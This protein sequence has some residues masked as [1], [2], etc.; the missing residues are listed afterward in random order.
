MIPW[1]AFHCLHCES[2]EAVQVSLACARSVHT[3]LVA[4]LQTPARSGLTGLSLAFR[5]L[6]AESCQL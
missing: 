2:M 3:S 4:G 5:P 6:P 1:A